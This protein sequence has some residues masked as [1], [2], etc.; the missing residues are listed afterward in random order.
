MAKT[1]EPTVAPLPPVE[2]MAGGAK[3]ELALKSAKPA[4]KKAGSKRPASKSAKKAQKGGAVVRTARTA[5][6]G[7]RYFKLIDGNSHA[8][9]GRY[10]GET[11]KQAASKSFTKILKRFKDTKK[12]A[13]KQMTIYLCESTRGSNRKV[14][15]YSA[16]RVKLETPQELEI[17]DK[18]T[19][20]VKTITYNYRNKI[21]KVAVPEQIGGAMKR[22]AKK[23]GSRMSQKLPCSESRPSQESRLKRSHSR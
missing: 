6:D 1:A 22:P 2:K 12:P 5:D 7:K 18:V 21:K 20:E 11:P 16:S 15:G 17:K 19:G 10:T 8:A 3:K 23:A 9:S 4:A 13:P 14:Y